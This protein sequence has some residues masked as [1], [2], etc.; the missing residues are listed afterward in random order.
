M[1]G[2]QLQVTFEAVL[3]AVDGDSERTPTSQEFSE[4]LDRMA[5]R[6]YDIDG[7]VDPV[8]WGQAS[9][10]KIEIQ[11]C[12]P[13]PDETEAVAACAMAVVHEISLAAGISLD[14]CHDMAG[15]TPTVAATEPEHQQIHDHADSCTRFV[16]TATR[17]TSES[18]P[19]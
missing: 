19:L 15:Q 11:L 12:F 3:A 1:D 6:L 17:H 10:G 8:L 13:A 16:L 7:L 9:N 4:T 14:R 5:D 18:V 2:T